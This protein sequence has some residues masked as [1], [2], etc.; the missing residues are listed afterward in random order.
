MAATMG[1]SSNNHFLD[2]LPALLTRR[3]Q[4][5]AA[6][7]T[8]GLILL[9][10]YSGSYSSYQS[11]PYKKPVN[12]F[13]GQSNGRFD[14]TWNY[15]RDKDNLLLTLDQCDAAFPGF[16]AEVDR[17]VDH[18]KGGVKEEDVDAIK[19]Q[20]G[21]VRVMIYD[22]QLYVIAKTG[23]IYS[24]ELATLHAI[25]RA[26]LTSPEVL[27]NIEFAFNA[28]DRIPS[29]P[30]W[31][32]A[33]REEDKHIWLIP[34]FG[35]YSWPE[36]KVGT[37]G[38]VRM[39]AEVEEQSGSWSWK[40]KHPQLFWR[41]ATMGLSL[42]DRLIE[43]TKGKPWADIKALDWHNKE[44]TD[45]DLKSMPEHCQYKYLM[46]TEGNS[47][48][49]R[50][51]YLQ[52]CRSVIVS[53]PLDWIEHHHPL[54]QSSGPEQNFVEVERSFENLEATILS[55]EKDQTKAERIAE[56]NKRT[57]REHYLT[58]AAEACYWRKLI[59]GWSTV[60]W[61]PRFWKLDADGNKVWRGLPVESF[62]L[63]RRLEWDPY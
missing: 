44:S 26:V 17:A 36:T 10:W 20:N 23:G 49:G 37:M 16:F 14:G 60:S 27:P 1:R 32:Y 13:N 61:E 45:K 9:F 30:L 58:P 2:R 62:L 4:V 35:Y 39:K 19:Q 6:A 57:F 8:F 11:G 63:E 18:W 21:Y 42:R 25:H 15:Q 38:E 29:V 40:Q 55:L 22:N 59:H 51:K 33:R 3:T 54:M 41:G 31:G 28:D 47:Y 7:L 5:L 56:N 52:N 46:Q 50:L 24:R 43:M 53:H 12:R 34:D 48:S